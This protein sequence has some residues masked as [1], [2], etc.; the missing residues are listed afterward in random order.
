MNKVRSWVTAHCLYEI[1]GIK[2]SED[3]TFEKRIKATEK[4]WNDFSKLTAKEK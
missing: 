4:Y 3:D 1:E 2:P